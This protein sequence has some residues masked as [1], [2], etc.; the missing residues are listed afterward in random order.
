MSILA[1]LMSSARCLE[2]FPRV[3]ELVLLHNRCHTFAVN[4]HLDA[5]M[6][7]RFIRCCGIWQ[8]SA[9]PCFTAGFSRGFLMGTGTHSTPDVASS[10]W[11]KQPQFASQTEIMQMV[12]IGNVYLFIYLY[13]WYSY[14]FESV[15]IMESQAGRPAYYTE[16]SAGIANWLLIYVLNTM[17][18]VVCRDHITAITFSSG[19][20]C[21]NRFCVYF[22]D[23]G[24]ASCCCLE[25]DQYQMFEDTIWKI[26]SLFQSNLAGAVSRASV[27]VLIDPEIMTQASL[28]VKIRGWW[29][30]TG[31]GALAKIY[32]K[33]LSDCDS[34]LTGAC[35]S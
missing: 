21:A 1:C 29:G 35:W 33:S 22:A 4:K 27:K 18:C 17:F 2:A 20:Q 5:F 8:N 11:S 3:T 15:I 19:S 30:W 6:R 23:L 12:Q 10:P 7:P 32:S 25:I 9:K 13:I 34:A 31:G 28:T 16:G 26:K 14:N 24:K